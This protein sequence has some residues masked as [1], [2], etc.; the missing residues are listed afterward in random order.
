MRAVVQARRVLSVWMAATVKIRV[1]PG[2]R[3]GTGSTAAMAATV[4][5]GR[6]VHWCACKCLANIRQSKSRFRLLVVPV[7]WP[8]LVANLARVARPRVAWFT[9]RMAARAAAQGL[10]ASQGRSVQ[11]VL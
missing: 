1:A 4:S 5:Q 11:R 9:Q 7:V 6:P 2:V 10:M 8:G 3:P